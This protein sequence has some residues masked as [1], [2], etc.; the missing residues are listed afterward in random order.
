MENRQANEI[1]AGFISPLFKG[2]LQ[3]RGLS[4]YQHHVEVQ[5]RYPVLGLV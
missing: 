5:W 3:F 2:T 4:T 1:E